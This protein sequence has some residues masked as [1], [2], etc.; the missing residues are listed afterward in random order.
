MQEKINTLKPELL[1]AIEKAD[2]LSALDEV[3][4]SAL[5]KNGQITGLMKT[6]GG[7]SPEERKT[8]GQVLNVFKNEIAAALDQK[9]EALETKALNEKLQSE[10]VDVTLP[11]RP[12]E[13]GRIHPISQVIEE[14]LT[15]FAQMGFELAEGPDIEDDWH[16][17][18]ALNMPAA[19]P[20][21]QMQATFFFPGGSLLR[22]Q[23]SGVQIR[24]ME[25][26][27]PPIKIVC[28]GRTYRRDYDATHTPM[29]HQIEGLV[30]DDKTNLANLKS[31]LLEFFKLFFE[32]DDVAVRFRPSYFPF[33]EPSYEM[34]LGGA[35][36]RN[37]GK[38]WIEL[39]GCGVVDPRVLQNCG[40]D[41]T[42]Y[43]GFAF[44]IGL[45]RLAM[46]KYGIKDLRPMFE[47]DMKWIKHYGFLPLDTPTVTSGLSLNGGRK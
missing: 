18:E 47:A 33:T 39:L 26:K 40:I 22:T 46:M 37:I 3:R 42:Q 34:D 17:F 20:A 6:L 10:S 2:T 19:H 41:S 25:A 24:T 45:D 4:V 7:L 1:R 36:A 21:R 27:K 5:G 32:T 23:T 12:E 13:Q 15:I 8:A 38:E 28:P 29:F 44:G 11:V 43:Q 35:M 9:K 14:T 30:I 16:N 31:V